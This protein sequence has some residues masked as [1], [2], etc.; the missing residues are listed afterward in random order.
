MSG[1]LVIFPVLSPILPG[2]SSVSSSLLFSLSCLRSCLPISQLVLQPG[3]LYPAPWSCL[4]SCLPG[5]YIRLPGLDFVLS[6]ILPPNLP[7]CSSAWDVVSGSLVMSPVLFSG[8]LCPIPWSCL[9]LISRFNLES[10]N[11]FFSLGCCSLPACSL[12]WDVVSNSLVSSP[13]FSLGMLYPTPY[14]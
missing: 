6:P 12:A 4:R 7:A 14:S 3:M 13:I 5:C 10:A 8:M 1:S 11:L 2:R 9:Y